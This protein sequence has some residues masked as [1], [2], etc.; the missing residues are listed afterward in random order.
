MQSNKRF[1]QLCDKL[2]FEIVP[3]ATM[4][5]WKLTR[6]S[7]IEAVIYHENFVMVVPK[8]I[9][10]STYPYMDIGG[11]PLRT[12]WEAEHRLYQYKYGQQA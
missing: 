6:R 8:K 10:L 12:Y 2:G 3:V 5:D 1:K 11:R 7:D 9:Y 4:I